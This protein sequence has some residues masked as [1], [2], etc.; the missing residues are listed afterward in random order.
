MY[1]CAVSS[2]QRSESSDDADR[3]TGHVQAF[4]SNGTGKSNLLI[5]S[6]DII[7]ALDN[8]K[9]IWVALHH[10]CGHVDLLDRI[11]GHVR[12]F[13]STEVLRAS[14]TRDTDLSELSINYSFS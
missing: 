7:C 2:T 4:N 10:P 13:R 1:Q 6:L 11:A 8:L 12:V 3:I 9:N 5:H 14:K